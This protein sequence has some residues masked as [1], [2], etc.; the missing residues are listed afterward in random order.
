MPYQSR[1]SRQVAF[2]LGGL[3]L[4]ALP[5]PAQTRRMIT[6]HVPAAVARIH[7]IGLLPETNRLRLVIGLP[8]Q[9]KAGLDGVIAGLYDPAGP[10][11]HQWLTPGQFT[12]RFG[13]TEEDYQKV[14]G[15]L[16]SNGLRVTS[17]CSNRMLVDVEGSV[18]AIEKAFHTSLYFYPH[19]TEN[20][21]FYAPDT[22]PSV[23]TGIPILHISGLDNFILVHRLGG[24]LKPLPLAAGSVNDDYTGSAPGGYFMG[25]DFRAAYAP[26]VTNNGAGQHVAIVDVGG[27]YYPND[28]Y[29]YETNA[30]LSTNI[31][32]TN[33]VTTFTA[34]WTNALSGTNT[35]DTEE[36]LDI[37]MAMSMAPGATIMNYEGEAHDVFNQIASDNKAKQMTLS[38]GFGIDAT[39]IQ[40]FQQFL[41]QGQALSQASGDGDAD[42]NGGTGL[43]GNPYATIVGGTTLTT[44]G[45]GGAWSSETTWNW[46]NGAG[47]GGG[48]SGYGIP[49][50]QQGINMTTNLG[51]TLYRNYPDVA[52]P[53]D[54]VFVVTH[55]GTFTGWVGGTSCASPLWAG[56]MALVNQQAASLGRNAV[57]FPNPAIYTIGRGSYASYT[58]VFHDITTG[59]TFNSQN[60]GRFVAYPGYD[61]CTGWGTP[62]GSNTINALAGIGTNDFVFYP[63]VGGISIVRGGSAAI[64]LTANRINGYAGTIGIS[65]SGLPTG[66]TYSLNPVGTTN[67]SLLTLF[68]DNAAVPATN[69]V[70]ITGASG[71]YVHSVAFG[72]IVTPPVP[73]AVQVN[74][75]AYYNRPGILP[76]GASNT[77]GLDGDGYCY[78]ANLLSPT[79]SWNGLAFTL[80]PTNANDAVSCSGQTISLPAD[81]FNSVEILATAVNG[82]QSAQN[83]TVTYSDNSTVTWTQSLSDWAFSQDYAGEAQAVSMA[84]RNTSGGGEDPTA[85]NLYGYTLPLNQ[86]KTVKSLTLPDDGNVVILAATLANDPVPVSLSSYYNRAGMYTDGATYTNPP[87]GG[88]DGGGYSYSATLLTGS[89]TWSNVMFDFGPANTTNVISAAGQVIAMPAGQYSSLR[90]LATG[91]QGDQAAQTFTVR[92][93]DGTSTGV[94]QSLSDW[95]TPQN[96]AGEAEAIICGHRNSADGSEDT[97]TFYL[98]GYSFPLNSGKVVQSLALPNDANVIV[99]ALSLVPEWQPTFNVSPFTLPGI[100]AGRN[101]SGN[102]ATNASDLNGDPLTFAKVSGPAWLNVSS[103]GAVSGTPLSANVGLNSFVVSATD[104]GNLSNTATMNL[105]VAAASPIVVSIAQSPGGILMNWSGGIAPYQPQAATN[106]ANPEWINVGAPTNASSLTVTPGNPASFYRIEGQ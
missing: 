13:P 29:V 42:L 5:A 17:L 22:E 60:P 106:L 81:A 105:T 71:P 101:Y 75:S 80:G 46:G 41:A 30:G 40:T 56:F 87:T 76:N 19:P 34:G 61:L 104:P 12:Q 88:A 91:V 39:I 86:T 52:M 28:I 50:W 7:A 44:S 95:F 67:I 11:Y 100:V 1:F 48:I 27:L 64:I 89:Q 33:I 92:Y 63:S 32:V 73:G 93:T 69:I 85:V 78:S 2:A 53:A 10:N 25:N 74:L 77:G 21:S 36:A 72:L 6:G 47:S 18:G 90:M 23:D 51:S 15:Y 26:G 54:G 9:N 24:A 96:Y 14:V 37:C 35:D 97:R 49:D 62:T 45:P 59:N 79:P 84:Y 99:T 8:L 57:G 102:I 103:A 83:F 98:Y 31:V 65:I 68:A 94:V 70:T 4:L 55:N 38:Y 43:T 58:N 66:V 16:E 3:L 20:R 82:S